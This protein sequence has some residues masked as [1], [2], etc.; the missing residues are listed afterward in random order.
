MGFCVPC[1]LPEYAKATRPAAVAHMVVLDAV[2]LGAIS[3]VLHDF[4]PR[5]SLHMFKKRGAKLFAPIDCGKQQA[6]ALMGALCIVLA[7][8]MKER[9]V[10]GKTAFAANAPGG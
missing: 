5:V 9:F 1:K 4:Q 3:V 2:V 6:A 10:A 8:C 7:A